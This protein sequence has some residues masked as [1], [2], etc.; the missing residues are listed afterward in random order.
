MRKGRVTERVAVSADDRR[1]VPKTLRS[2]TDI[3][4]SMLVLNCTSRSGS[5]TGPAGCR[6][7]DPYRYS[8]CGQGRKYSEFI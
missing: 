8:N 6:R 2:S 4:V 1:A 7:L 5:F 3:T